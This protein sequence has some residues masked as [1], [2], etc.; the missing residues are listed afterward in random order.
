[1]YT[2]YNVLYIHVYMYARM[3]ACMHACMHVCMFLLRRACIFA[4]VYLKSHV[5]VFVDIYSIHI[6]LHACAGSCCAGTNSSGESSAA[7]HPTG[8][9]CA[10]SILLP[11]EFICLR[12]QTQTPIPQHR[13]LH[14]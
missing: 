5:Q 8:P 3:C 1:M 11:Y 7:F 6:R 12:T 4:D 13:K 9:Y 10:C 2:Y 14:L